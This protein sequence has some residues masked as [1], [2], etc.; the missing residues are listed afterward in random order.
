M[1]RSVPITLLMRIRLWF[2]S[3]R[4]SWLKMKFRGKRKR[5]PNGEISDAARRCAMT[6]RITIELAGPPQGKGRAR[7]FVNRATGRADVYTPGKTRTYEAQLRYAAQQSMGERLPTE[8]PVRVVVDAR[9]P[10]A[11]SWSK[12]KQTAARN[13][14][15]WPCTT[16]D[17][18]NLLKT[19]D[20]L[21]GI[22]WKDDKQIVVAIVRKL[23]SDRP[24]LTVC[25]DSLEPRVTLPDV[26]E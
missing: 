21:N 1:K 19:L 12:K 4:V 17:A 18:D 2:A 14:H 3:L 5:P 13:G 26:T 10:I 16:P 20:S 23:Y 7:A 22:V 15:A 8:H 24:G 25:V 11:T 6:L 9:F